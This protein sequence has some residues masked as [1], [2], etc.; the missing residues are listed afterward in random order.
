MVAMAEKCLA[1]KLDTAM[2]VISEFEEIDF[3]NKIEVPG[4][5]EER[6]VKPKAEVVG[7]DSY[8]E[9]GNA[10]ENQKPTKKPME[11]HEEKTKWDELLHEY[12]KIAGHIEQLQYKDGPLQVEELEGF[13][14]YFTSTSKSKTRIN[15]SYRFTS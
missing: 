3:T 2:D 12:K 7:A 1:E 6:I 14:E 5:V 8:L 15:R 13:T 4:F 10:I 9:F 11:F